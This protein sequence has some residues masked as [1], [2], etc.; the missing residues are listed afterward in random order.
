M[1]TCLHRYT[2]AYSGYV[3]T[4]LLCIHLRL[5]KA[6]HG[7]HAASLK[8]PR[9]HGF[10]S[11][12]QSSFN[13]VMLFKFPLDYIGHNGLFLLVEHAPCQAAKGS[14]APVERNLRGSNE[15]LNQQASGSRLAAQTR[16]M[17]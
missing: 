17:L 7:T 12:R 8:R 4:I 9:L 1:Y 10:K 11:G 13:S 14:N 5:Y 3:H 15:T 6:L 2:Q 16:P